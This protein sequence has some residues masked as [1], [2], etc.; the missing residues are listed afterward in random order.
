MTHTLKKIKIYDLS[1]ELNLR[2]S[3]LIEFL[4]KKGY[5]VNGHMS[6]VTPEMMSAILGHFKKEKN[7]ADLHQK[8]LNEFRSSNGNPSWRIMARPLVRRKRR[9]KRKKIKGSK[10][11]SVRPFFTAFETNRRRH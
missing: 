7:L 2:S 9:R 1:K 6:P 5:E 3:A 4:I 8:K 10:K 11:K